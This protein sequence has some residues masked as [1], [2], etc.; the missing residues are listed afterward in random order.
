VLHWQNQD[1]TGDNLVNFITIIDADIS[2]FQE[3][4]QDGKTRIVAWY[5]LS[6]LHGE[7]LTSACRSILD[8]YTWQ[9]DS[10]KLRLPVAEPKRVK[11]NRV[12]PTQ[13][14]SISFDV[15]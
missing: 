1:G 9:L 4:P 8:A 14:P 10:M 3:F 5:F 6:L 11:V 15:E 12:R 7:S 2:T 13:R